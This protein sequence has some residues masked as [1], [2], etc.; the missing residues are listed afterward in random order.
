MEEDK[1]TTYT[2]RDRDWTI[3]EY[4]RSNMGQG[5]TLATPVF[6]LGEASEFLPAWL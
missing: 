6:S 2:G 4:L 5:E 3:A 1:E